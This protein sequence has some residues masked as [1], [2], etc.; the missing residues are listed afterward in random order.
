MT[1]TVLSTHARRYL[2]GRLPAWVEPRWFGSAQ[3]LMALAPEAE[4]GWFDGASFPSALDAPEIAKKLKWL[5]TF[6]AGVEVWPLELLRKRSI[7]FTNGTGVNNI[8]VAE[9][10]LLGMLVIA[11]GYRDVVRAQDKRE[12][13]HDAP[14]K[15]ELHGTKALIVG[16]GAIGKR[17]G[18]MLAPFEVEVTEVRRSP[19]PGVLAPDEWRARLGEFDWV[20]IAVPAT[21]DTE[22]MFG[23]EEFSAM[24]RGAGILNFARGTVI[25][26]AALAAAIESGQLGG[27][28]LDVTDPEPLPPD[29]PLWAY[30]NVHITSHLS[31]RSQT[32]LFRRASERFLENLGRWERGEPLHGLVDLG[33]GY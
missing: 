23:A 1:V 18:A 16:A 11:K 28:F 4:I 33:L 6:A 27:A 5:N 19:A 30:D 2:D 26:Q 21:A 20:I 22:S 9:Y 32:A 8:A 15:L 31:G 12:W 17:I 29:D 25:D 7:A 14:G 24:K 10:A 3:E 13:L